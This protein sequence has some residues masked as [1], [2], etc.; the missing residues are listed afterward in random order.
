MA[1]REEEIGCI[2]KDHGSDSTCRKLIEPG[3]TMCPYH[4]LVTEHRRKQEQAKL[5]AKRDAPRKP[6]KRAAHE[7]VARYF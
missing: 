1:T 3:T 6:K 7:E 5:E 2:F 4:N